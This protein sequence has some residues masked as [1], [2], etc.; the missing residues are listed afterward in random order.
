MPRAPYYKRKLIEWISSLEAKNYPSST[1]ECYGR[2]IN[3]IWKYGKK[4]GW[5]MNPKKL[6]PKQLTYYLENLKHL[7]T[8]TQSLYGRVLLIFLK[9]CGNRQFEEFRFKIK[10]ERSRVDWLTVEEASDILA[11]A[12]TMWIM[13]METMFIYTGIRRSELAHLR[14]SDV[15]EDFILVV[16][17]GRKARRIPVAPELWNMMRPYT[18]WRRTRGGEFFLIHPQ[19]GALPEGPYAAESIGGCIWD[20]SKLYGRHFSPHTFRRSY[21]RHLYKAGMALVEIQR[22]YG[23]ASVEMTIRYLGI[24]EEDLSTSLSRYQPSYSR[25]SS[26]A[27]AEQ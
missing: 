21:G 23:H 5:P 15:H 2:I 4:N 3:R 11:S 25:K 14:L 8:G 13:A 22:L 20:H 12:P 27:K 26:L 19:I 7:S 1:I 10:V 18:D 17:K 24:T 16:G 9:W 6:Q